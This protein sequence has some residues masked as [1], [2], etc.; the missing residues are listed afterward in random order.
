MSRSKAN[1][2]IQLLT[3]YRGCSPESAEA[4]ARVMRSY[5]GIESRSFLSLESASHRTI[6]FC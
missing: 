4:R 2:A 3:D 6:M 1:A 5:K